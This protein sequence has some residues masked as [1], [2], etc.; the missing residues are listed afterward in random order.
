VIVMPFTFSIVN[1]IALG[2]ISFVV[3]K[4]VTGR[5]K[6]VSGLLLALAVI[7]VLKLLF[8]SA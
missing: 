4:M 7:F 5:R 8:L 2:M 1:G 3:L 6:E